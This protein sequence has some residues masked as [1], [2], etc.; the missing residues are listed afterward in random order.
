[1]PES[2]ENWLAAGAVECAELDKKLGPINLQLTAVQAL[3]LLGYLQVA[4][5]HPK[6]LAA[7]L[8]PSH[9]Q[10]TMVAKSIENLFVDSPACAHMI[11]RGW[12]AESQTG[13]IQ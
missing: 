13:V 12:G 3:T 2:P 9:K 6:V 5:R 10:I 11:R 8:S 7:P 4:M 1:M